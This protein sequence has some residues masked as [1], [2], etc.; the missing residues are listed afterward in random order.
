MHPSVTNSWKEHALKC[1]IFWQLA[2]KFLQALFEEWHQSIKTQKNE[3][4]NKMLW[5]DG[6]LLNYCLC[7]HH[8]KCA[9]PYNK[10]ALK[11]LICIQRTMSAWVFQCLP[12]SFQHP[13]KNLFNLLSQELHLLSDICMH[14]LKL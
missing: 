5:I 9:P 3:D 2:Q 7:F 8:F 1:Q 13:S 4:E 12:K 6:C 11:I 14:D 10:E